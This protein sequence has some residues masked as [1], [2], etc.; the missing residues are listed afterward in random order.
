MPDPVIDPTPVP[1]GPAPN[2]N[3]GPI[4]PIGDLF[5]AAAD[6]AAPAF[7]VG[8]DPTI[9]ITIIQALVA[10]FSG[11]MKPP[12]PNAARQHV[13]DA[14]H[15]GN[16]DNGTIRISTHQAMRAAKRA[17]TRISKEEAR[18]TAIA[19]LDQ[20]RLSDDGTIQ[21]AMDATKSA[22]GDDTE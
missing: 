2:P 12:T 7:P 8:F 5:Q 17:K 4:P 21:A 10:I 11:C 15:N 16:Y 1:P 14:Y 13:L 3:P 19:T 6:V 9:I 22:A 20:I 18:A